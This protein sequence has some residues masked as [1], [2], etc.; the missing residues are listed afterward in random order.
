MKSSLSKR[1]FLEDIT[2]LVDYLPADIYRTRR[3]PHVEAYDLNP[4]KL[5]SHFGAPGSALRIICSFPFM[6][7]CFFRTLTASRRLTVCLSSA[8]INDRTE[9]KESF[10][11]ILESPSWKCFRVS[12]GLQTSW[13][14]PFRLS[15]TLSLDK[16]RNVAHSLVCRT[17][18]LSLLWKTG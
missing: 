11:L 14:F 7:K 13:K 3:P 9:F 4:W 18:D 1:Y 17:D 16:H 8:L 10:V 12:F 5:I 6:F 2:N 15:S